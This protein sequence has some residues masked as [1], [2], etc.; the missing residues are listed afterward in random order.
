MSYHRLDI[1]NE[2]LQVKNLHVHYY[3]DWLGKI[4]TER[5]EKQTL[6]KVSIVQLGSSSIFTLVRK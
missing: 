1:D 4:E 5:L 6:L 2:K 3:W